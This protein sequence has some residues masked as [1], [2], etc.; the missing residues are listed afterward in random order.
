V[1]K[2]ARAV[3]QWYHTNETRMTQLERARVRHALR[4][5]RAEGF[6]EETYPGKF[7]RRRVEDLMNIDPDK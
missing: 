1:F 6:L 7:L 3:E 4:L 2:F 5:E